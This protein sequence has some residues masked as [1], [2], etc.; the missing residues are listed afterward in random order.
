MPTFVE[1]LDD[2]PEY[3]D[4]PPHLQSAAY[5]KQIGKSTGKYAYDPTQAMAPEGA[6]YGLASLQASY[7]GISRDRLLE[8]MG[9]TS[10]IG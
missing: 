8:M 4:L 9:Y 10:N 1:W 3:E 5:R 6:G 7:P 2:N